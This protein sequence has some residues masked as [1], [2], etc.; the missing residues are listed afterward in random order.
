MADTY[1]WTG[2]GDGIYWFTA[3][4]WFDATTGT[5]AASAP[6]AAATVDFT[7]SASDVSGGADVA[8]V[9][10]AP[11]AQ[12]SLGT[13][14]GG[15]TYH[16][17]NLSVGQS[18][19]LTL[20]GGTSMTVGTAD[21]GSSAGLDISRAWWV[22]VS[23]QDP[24][25]AADAVTAPA[26]EGY[27]GPISASID[28]LTMQQGAAVMLGA[29]NLGIGVL[30]DSSDGAGSA[31]NPPGFSGTGQIVAPLHGDLSLACFVAGTRIATEAG[32][33]AVESLRP[34][35]RV[36]TAAGRLAPVRWIGL[37]TQAMGAPVR[38][39]AGAIAPGVPR[40]D[41]LLS[42]DHAVFL[43]GALIPAHRLCNGATV[44]AEPGTRRVT[45]VH[46]ELDRHDLLLAEGMA[47][48]SYLD[49]GNRSQFERTLG[50]CG[51]IAT[52]TPPAGGRMAETLAAY[53]EAGCTELVLDGER[54]WR[55][56]RRLL[57]RARA[58]GWRLG[59]DGAPR[60]LAGARALAGRREADGTLRF[61]LPPGTGSAV[62]VSRSFVPSELDPARHDGRRL[63]VAAALTLDG[64][65]LAEAAFGPG[66]YAPDAGCAWR[67]SDGAARLL[68]VPSARPACL[69]VRLMAAGARYWREPA[70]VRAAA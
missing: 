59:S 30:N 20:L 13:L 69:S 45:Y 14:P 68:L 44:R 16:F 47:S 50:A 61:T 18:A 35:D 40:R 39:A 66:W 70:S 22:G 42:P 4:N 56:H 1:I 54:L 6:G 28:E 63:G 51:G 26:A 19:T 49:T 48:E 12:V 55:A 38:L 23:T 34:G 46:V 33:A 60:L 36:R 37:R 9:N 3:A 57:A 52:L 5:V 8:A 10:I 7:A 43:D 17:G 2:K 67:C 15:A 32:E 58:L 27:P 31:T 21:L 65:P 53:A 64:A 11:G 29:N 25:A 41:V 24:N 62:L